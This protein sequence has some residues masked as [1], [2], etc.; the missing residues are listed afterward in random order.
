MGTTS[1]QLG[2][3]S[4]AVTLAYVLA[5]AH[6]QGNPAGTIIFAGPAAATAASALAGAAAAKGSRWWLL[7]LLGP[8]LFAALGAMLLATAHV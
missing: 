6:F 1:R 5:S 7:A 3:A 4:V 8:W 2:I